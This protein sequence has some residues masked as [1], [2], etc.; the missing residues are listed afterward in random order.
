MSI[1]IWLCDLCYTQQIVSSEVMPAAVGS[2]A[3]FA[4]ALV[5]DVENVQ[6]FKYP[7]KLIEA[8]EN[9]APHIIGFS[10]YCWNFEL[11][12]A[13]AQLFKQKFPH[14]VVV[15]GGPNYPVDLPSQEQFLHDYPAVDFYIV[16]EG[17]LPFSKLVEAL[18][19]SNFD[20][21]T[22]KNFKIG[23][24]H[25]IAKDG[26]F[27][28]PPLM[29]RLRDLSV[30]PSPYATGK[31]DDFFDGALMPIL[32][33]NRGCPF[34]C[35]FCTEGHTY[36]QKI[37]KNSQEKIAAEVDYIGKK[38][39]ELRAA[40]GRNDLFIA[41]SNFGMFKE[42]LETCHHLARSQELHGWPEYVKVATGKNQKQ[43]VL[44]ASRILNGAISLSGSVQSLDPEVLDN[45]KRSN[46][47]AHKLMELAIEANQIG[48]NS[49]AEVIL[50]LPGDTKEKHLKTIETLLDAGFTYIAMFQLMML[51]GSEIATPEIRQQY[52]M[53]T[54]FRVVPRC[55]GNYKI[56]GS[57]IIAAEIEEIVTS[58][59]TLSFDDYLYCRRFNLMVTIF[60]NDAVF[61]G[62][63]KL[64]RHL[65]ISRFA[66]IKV[67]FDCQ[68]SG[69]MTDLIASFLKDTKEELWDS[70]E[71][72]VAFTRKAENIEK[73]I[74][75][76]LGANLIYTYQALAINNHLAELA[77]IARQT[78]L[79]VIA[80]E[81]KISSRIEAL[82]DDILTYEVMR[83]IDLFN[84]S[85]DPL[86]AQLNH[87]IPGFMASQD[88]TALSE[89][90]FDQAQEF[91]F[92]LNEEQIDTIK[93][94]L[95]TYGT[96]T[97]GM[98]RILARVHMK[99]LMRQ[100]TLR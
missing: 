50:A 34:T 69:E 28:S 57:A 13:F 58:L 3:T 96:S 5:D 60:Y 45:I 54:Q 56:G 85:Y 7:E 33:T 35:I 78:I 62:L 8:L 44:E 19:E 26:E 9:G 18:I 22:V 30:I 74:H 6:V 98:T 95:N 16:K 52:D 12:Y 21:E 71:E 48:A 49:Y 51:I 87:D 77:Q 80:D 92:E 40:G 36:F 63:L 64:L 70:R 82:V 25:T 47:D 76:E 15:M 42:D 1:Q 14:T 84:G 86:Y 39:A 38:M 23:G 4:E 17:E 75:G 2:I 41:D 27:S 67:I 91:R 94:A 88:G 81:G 93:R 11:S 66:W 53:R 29:D 24:V 43:R 31:L 99:S 72:L 83:K 68:M 10:N 79:Q 61:L 32:Q 46:I 59:N 100:V 90:V 65:E 73:Y 20:I 97:V 89:I 55:Y 37:Y